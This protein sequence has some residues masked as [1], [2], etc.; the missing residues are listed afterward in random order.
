MTRRVVAAI[1][2]CCLV[3][4]GPAT[5]A[6]EAAGPEWVAVGPDGGGGWWEILVSPSDPDV[7]YAGSELSGL[8]RSTDAGRSWTAIVGDPVRLQLLAVHPTRPDVLFASYGFTGNGPPLFGL[9]RSS[10][11][12]ATWRSIGDAAHAPSAANFH[13]IIPDP[14]TAGGVLVGTDTGEVWRVTPSAEWTRVTSGLPMVQALALR[15]Q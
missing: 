7:I 5:T 8:F 11:G 10:D 12:G 15:P 2:G 9:N 4:A 14:E 13:A 3:L 1:L 6:G